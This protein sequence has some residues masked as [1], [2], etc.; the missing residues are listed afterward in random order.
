MMW[1]T[2]CSCTTCTLSWQHCV[3]CYVTPGVDHNLE[4][5]D[6]FFWCVVKSL[7]SVLYRVLVRVLSAY[8]CL[9]CLGW[10]T[11]VELIC[12]MSRLQNNGLL[13]LWCQ[14]SGSMEPDACRL[15]R[16]LPYSLTTTDFRSWGLDETDGTGRDQQEYK[17]VSAGTFR[18]WT[19]RKGLCNFDLYTALPTLTSQLKFLFWLSF[20]SLVP[21]LALPVILYYWACL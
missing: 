17:R 12:F 18:H 9:F 16:H 8:S 15:L 4:D 13:C 21:T 6:E 2:S 20:L 19:H 10:R 14:P 3:N 5:E 11:R 7:Q 1:Q